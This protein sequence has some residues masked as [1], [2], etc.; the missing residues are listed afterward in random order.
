MPLKQMAR[1]GESRRAESETARVVPIPQ[2]WRRS[3]KSSNPKIKTVSMS[4]ATAA[5]AATATAT[6]EQCALCKATAGS[7]GKLRTCGGCGIVKYCSAEHQKEDWKKHKG[8]CAQKVRSRCASGRRTTRLPGSLNSVFCRRA[9]VF[10]ERLQHKQDKA[11]N[12]LETHLRKGMTPQRRPS[13]CEFNVAVDPR[14]VWGFLVRVCIRFVCLH[15]HGRQR[16]PGHVGRSETHQPIW[17]VERA[18]A[19]LEG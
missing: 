14:F 3:H 11:S 1:S 7:D 19:R 5:T 4:A 16:C 8:T 18:S 15:R 17:S 9:C 2:N 13:H 6:V 12:P 10:P